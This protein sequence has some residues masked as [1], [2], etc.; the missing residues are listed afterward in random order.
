MPAARRQWWATS[1]KLKIAEYGPEMRG[2]DRSC[3]SD[4]IFQRISESMRFSEVQQLMRLLSE[5]CNETSFGVMKLL[6]GV[7]R[8]RPTVST[9]VTA[10]T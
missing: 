8:Y 7:R 4:E 3:F 1:E 10:V 2:S 9:A 5:V 6:S